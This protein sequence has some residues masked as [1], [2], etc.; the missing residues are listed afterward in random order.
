MP[1]VL[2]RLLGRPVCDIIQLIM[3]TSSAYFLTALVAAL[4]IGGLSLGGVFAGPCSQPITYRVGTIDERFSIATSTAKEILAEAEAV[5]EENTDKENEL[6]MYDPDGD[7]AVNFIF[8]DR[9]QTT[10]AVDQ[11]ESALSDLEMS[12]DDIISNYEAAK[13]A[14]ETALRD[15]RSAQA[16][17]EERLSA[18]NQRVRMWNDR[19]GAPPEVHEEL[20]AKKR[21]LSQELESLRT[22][23]RELERLRKTVNTFAS[24]GNVVAREYNQTATTFSSRFGGAREFN[25]ATYVGEA[26]NVYQFEEADDLRL[27]LTHEFGHALGIDHVDDSESIMYYLMEDQGLENP[28]LSPADLAAFRDICSNE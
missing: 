10:N 21:R 15:Y 18:Y 14:H 3:S 5:W 23:E 1:T 2:L 13:S 24:R 12:H 25:Q 11:Y 4:G 19:G 27:A 22:F 20:L 8:D 6:F 26:I 7:V 16:Q 9:Q 17:Y 28:R